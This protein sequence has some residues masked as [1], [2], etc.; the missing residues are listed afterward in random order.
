MSRIFTPVSVLLFDYKIFLQFMIRDLVAKFIYYD[1]FNLA[2]DEEIFTF[3]WLK[4]KE[5]RGKG[6]V[7]RVLETHLNVKK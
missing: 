3:L 1:D 5:G 4:D 7:F 2:R 6:S